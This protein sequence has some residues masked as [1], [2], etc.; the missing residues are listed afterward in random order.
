MDAT[1]VGSVIAAF[2]GLGGAVFAA[3]ASIRAGHIQREALEQAEAR[4]RELDA[5]QVEAEAYARARQ[6][7]DDVIQRLEHDLQRV[8]GELE[9]I[10]SQL[11]RERTV[12]D[13]LRSRLRGVEDTVHEMRAP[14]EELKQQ[15]AEH[16]SPPPPPPSGPGR[17]RD[18]LGQNGGDL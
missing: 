17:F 3:K 11:D 8:T 14:I 2:G 4:K 1:I 7:Y 15:Q 5:R 9:R 13:E 10:R 6:F 12:S 18:F 16:P